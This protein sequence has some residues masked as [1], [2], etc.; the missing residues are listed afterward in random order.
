MSSTPPIPSL[1]SG[2][3]TPTNQSTHTFTPEQ[4]YQGLINVPEEKKERKDKN[5]PMPGGRRK[6]RRKSR[7]KRKSKRK[8]RKSRKKRRKTRRRYRRGGTRKY[9]D[10]DIM[11]ATMSLRKMSPLT[12]K[13]YLY[14]N[15]YIGGPLHDSIIEAQQ[16]KKFKQATAKAMEHSK[17]IENQQ[18]G[19]RLKRKS[20][21]KRRRRRTRRKLQRGGAGGVEAENWRPNNTYGFIKAADFSSKIPTDSY[22]SYTANPSINCVT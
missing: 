11:K 21:R 14:K 3:Q 20:R 16:K 7:R 15:K 5:A 18:A 6:K 19:R 10:S 9:S 4:L 1:P 12:K 22:P 2:Y 17:A 8:R 13:A